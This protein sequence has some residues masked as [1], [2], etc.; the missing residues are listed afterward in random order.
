MAEAT[1]AANHPRRAAP[2]SS[3]NGATDS[4]ARTAVEAAAAGRTAML[5][6]AAATAHEGHGCVT[7]RYRSDRHRLSRPASEE[8]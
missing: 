4:P 7:L 6:E 2:R 8:R 5:T 3:G 1:R